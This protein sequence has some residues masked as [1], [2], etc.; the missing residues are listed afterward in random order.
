MFITCACE[1][2]LTLKRFFNL[3]KLN[4]SRDLSLMTETVRVIFFNFFLT[5]YSLFNNCLGWSILLFSLCSV[6]E[7]VFKRK[8]YECLKSK[9]TFN[10]LY[11]FF[12]ISL[13]LA[14]LHILL[15]HIKLSVSKN[16]M[17]FNCLYHVDLI[18]EYCTESGVQANCDVT[19]VIWIKHLCIYV[20]IFVS[21]RLQPRK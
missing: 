10:K 9:I 20:C 13:H 2:I 17:L 12:L 1:F 8:K 5:N 3:F 18:G 4:I 19:Q 11:S 15:Y 16:I 21:V 6:N 14:T 7:R